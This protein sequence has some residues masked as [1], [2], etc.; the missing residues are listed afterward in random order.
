VEGAVA[1]FSQK[2]GGASVLAS[3]KHKESAHQRPARSLAASNG[4]TSEEEIAVFGWSAIS[5]GFLKQHCANT[6]REEGFLHFV[7]LV[8]FV[9]PDA[10]DRN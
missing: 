7:C 4:V 3:R 2:V 6:R 9:V 5:Y 8:Y 10:G 1:Q